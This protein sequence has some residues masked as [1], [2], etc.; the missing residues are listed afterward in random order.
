MLHLC[1][2]ALESPLIKSLWENILQECKDLPKQTTK[3]CLENIVK[4]Y[5]KVRSFSYARDYVIK[6]KIKLKAA[7]SKGLRKELKRHG[8]AT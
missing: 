5:I 8:I 7:K 3:L 1:N 4:L 6:F 2:E